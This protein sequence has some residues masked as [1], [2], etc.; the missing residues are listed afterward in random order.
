MR[1]QRS[2]QDCLQIEFIYI[3]IYIYM[4]GNNYTY[5]FSSAYSLNVRQDIVKVFEAK[6]K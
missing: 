3:Y 5:E 2:K 4:D 1:P 6:L